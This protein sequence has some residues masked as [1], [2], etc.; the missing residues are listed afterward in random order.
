MKYKMKKVKRFSKLRIIEHL[1]HIL[2]FSIMFITGFP[3][4]YY[5]LD[6]SQWV[7]TKASG[8]E[9][10]RII[11]HSMGI[12]FILLFFIHILISTFGIL[13]YNWKTT[14]FIS[15]EDFKNLIDD[16]K[17]FLGL[18][19]IPAKCG[20]YSYKQK[21]QYWSVFISSFI[22]ILSGLIMLYP[23]FF[24]IFLQG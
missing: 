15:H 16:L 12:I 18:N 6:V 22:M 9:N 24:T 5:T 17:Y 1:F 2:I 19:N 11:H 14:M 8:I 20:R 4:K 23:F 10:L 7:I 13:K 3:Q 21:F